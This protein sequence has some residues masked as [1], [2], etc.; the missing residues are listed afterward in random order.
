MTGDERAAQP[1]HT[2]S[3]TGGYNN[4]HISISEAIIHHRGMLCPAPVAQ[5][6]SG[7]EA[8]HER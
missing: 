3:R 2:T 7:A 4:D 1:A 8:C 6:T 5:N